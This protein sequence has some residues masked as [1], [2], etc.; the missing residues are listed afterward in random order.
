M[1]VARGYDLRVRGV[2][3]VAGVFGVVGGFKRFS[4]AAA[5]LSPSFAARWNHLTALLQQFSRCARRSVASEPGAYL[6]AF[7][8]QTALSQRSTQ[9]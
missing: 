4:L 2:S 9:L 8:S 1:R 5:R 7:P 3:G 6:Q